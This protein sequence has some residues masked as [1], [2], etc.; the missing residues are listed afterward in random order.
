MPTTMATKKITD[1]AAAANKIIH[2]HM[3]AKFGLASGCPTESFLALTVRVVPATSAA[4]THRRAKW[5]EPRI[6]LQI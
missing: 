2:A 1:T 6:F 3:A 5:S 4:M